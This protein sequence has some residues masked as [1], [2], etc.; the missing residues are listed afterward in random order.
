MV[1]RDDAYAPLAREPK[2]ADRATQQLQSLITRRTFQPGDRLPSERELGSRLGVSRTVIREALRALSTKGLVEVRD[3][4]GAYVRAPSTDLVS[5][6]LGI[7]VSHMETGDVT[8]GNILEMRRI[9]EIEM[10]GL[11][12]ERRGADDLAELERLL[13]LMARPGS[14]RGDWAKIDYEFH[15]RVAIASKNPLFPIVLRSISEVLMRARLLGVRLPDYQAKALHHHRN[16]YEAIRARSLRE[17]PGRDGRPSARSR[18]DDAASAGGGSR[19]DR[20]PSVSMPRKGKARRCGSEN[21]GVGPR[22]DPAQDDVS[23]DLESGDDMN[24]QIQFLGLGAFRITLSD[25]R[26]VMIDPCLERLN[27]VSPV[28]VMDLERVDLLLVTHLAGDH[29][30]EAADVAKRFRCPVVCGPEVKYF[31][32]CQGVDPKQFRVLTW[33]AQTNPNGI[34]VRAVPSFHAS[35]GLAPDGKWLSGAPMGFILY[36][37]DRCR[38]YH[39]GDTAIFS[40]LNDR[41]AVSTHRRAVLCGHADA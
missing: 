34:R 24:T 27:P 38:I 8:S 21:S 31:L 19:G 3:G 9:L 6:L 11:A 7:C 33:N 13:G 35:V 30:G 22:T 4:A 5:E 16:V 10:S 25:G 1:S 26:V 28:K 20:I 18:A 12:A 41:R 39:S 37:S 2:L 29:L 23:G 15:D 17:G 14:S 36:A 32:T 40:D